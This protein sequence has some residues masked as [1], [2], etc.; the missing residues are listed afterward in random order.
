MHSIKCENCHRAV[1]PDKDSVSFQLGMNIGFFAIVIPAIIAIH[2]FHTNFITAVI[3][4]LIVV[5]I[6]FIFDT[7]QQNIA[8]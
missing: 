4:G 5:L 2:I 1:A 8:L 7:T 6:A 3:A